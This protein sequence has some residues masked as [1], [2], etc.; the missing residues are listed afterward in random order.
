MVFASDE[1]LHFPGDIEKIF[2]K[3][4][5]KMRHERKADRSPGTPAKQT[6][7]AAKHGTTVNHENEKGKKFFCKILDSITPRALYLSFPV[8]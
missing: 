2:A 5:M 7:E 8:F 6:M 3:P 4:R 1:I